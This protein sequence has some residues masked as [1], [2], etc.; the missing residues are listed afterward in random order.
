MRIIG[1]PPNFW[2]LS[3]QTESSNQQTLLWRRPH[4]NEFQPPCPQRY[5]ARV[6]NGTSGL[7]PPRFLNTRRRSL[8]IY[9]SRSVMHHVDLRR[10]PYALVGQKRRA[11]VCS[12]AAR[13]PHI[14][15]PACRLPRSRRWCYTR[16]IASI[17]GPS[18]VEG[19]VRAVAATW[20][21]ASCCQL[22]E[23]NRVDRLHPDAPAVPNEKEVRPSLPATSWMSWSNWPAMCGSTRRRCEGWATRLLQEMSTGSLNCPIA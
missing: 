17:H 19:S 3:Q 7:G 20:V 10:M 6:D 18:T 9:R 11:A 15:R 22:R 4:A 13:T 5:R 8:A 12:V 21:C 23:G 2:S 16:G 14:T 1:A